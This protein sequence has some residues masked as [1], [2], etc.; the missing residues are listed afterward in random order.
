MPVKQLFRK[1]PGRGGELKLT[2]K[3]APGFSGGEISSRQKNNLT[4][5]AIAPGR[6]GERKCNQNVTPGPGGGEIKF[7]KWAWGRG[8]PGK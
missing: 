7:G 1:T 3:A 4:K 6:G 8:L 2:L 5:K